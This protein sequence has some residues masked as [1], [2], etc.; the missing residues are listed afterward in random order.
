MITLVCAIVVVGCAATKRA[1]PP[2]EW[3]GLER[4]EVKGLGAVYVRPNV[5]FPPYKTV[6]LDPVEVAFSKDWDPNTSRELSRHLNADD[7]QKI[8]TGL[9][10]MFR[11]SFSEQLSKGGYSLTETPSDETMRVSAAVI[12]LYINAPDTMV[13]GRSRTYTTETGRMT[14]VME[15][16]DAPSGQLLARVVDRR[17]A[18]SPGGYLQWTNSVTNQADARVILDGWAKQLRA[19]LDRLNG[20]ASS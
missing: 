18:E 14:L 9:A 15:I 2:A 16:R 6:L 1:E 10:G 3:D 17:L 5:Q 20:R 8:K 4:R 13:A 12:D 7:L 11:E 19:A